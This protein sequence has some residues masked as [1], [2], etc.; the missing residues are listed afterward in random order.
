MPSVDWPTRIITV[1][2]AE[3]ALLSGATYELDLNQFRLDLIALETTEGIAYPSTHQ[4]TAPITFGG[5]TLSRVIEFINGYQVTF[6]DTGTPYNVSA[7]GANSNILDVY[8]PVPGVSLAVN[9]SVSL[10]VATIRDEIWNATMANYTVAG[11]AGQQQTASSTLLDDTLASHSTAGTIGEA[12]QQA[13]TPALFSADLLDTAL[14][15]HTTLGTAGL[16]LQNAADP[17]LFSADLLDT[18]MAAHTVAGSVAEAVRDGQD[19]TR[20]VEATLDADA[21]SYQVAGSIGEAISNAANLLDNLQAS[22]LGIGTIGASINTA[23]VNAGTGGGTAV[24]TAPQM[25]VSYDED[26]SQIDIIAWLSTGSV[27]Q[28]SPTSISMTWRNQDGSVLF[29]VSTANFA[30]TA[31]GYYEITQSQAL[32][33]NSLYFVETAITDGSGTYTSTMSVSTS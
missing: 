22:H 18:A 25:S 14:S 11:S 26:N 5:T 6:E 3:M 23:A 16:A 13:A 27:I 31:S 28:S 20:F 30:L 9:N 2:Q 8:I 10:D 1:N 29:A 21:A 24:E 12:I 17:T 4:H 15:A 19:T 32:A 33:G 7:T